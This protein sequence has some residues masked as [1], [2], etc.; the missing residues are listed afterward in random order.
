MAFA[1]LFKIR[2]AYYV[3]LDATPIKLN[4]FVKVPHSSEVEITVVIGNYLFR[5]PIWVD[6]ILCII[7][8]DIGS[9]TYFGTYF[10]AKATY[11]AT[12]SFKEYIKR[13]STF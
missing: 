8:E 12:L 1:I 13:T 6:N 4:L 10:N 5:L 2:S 9:S 11:R 7:V 3:H